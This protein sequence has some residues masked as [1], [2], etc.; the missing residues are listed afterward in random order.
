MQAL[1]MPI[2]TAPISPLDWRP[3]WV[4]ALN[5]PKVE[6]D[7]VA[8]LFDCEPTEAARRRQR[9]AENLAWL[10]NEDARG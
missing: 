9:F 6:V 10:R 3:E 5:P 4:C 8:R 1:E 2:P 7:R